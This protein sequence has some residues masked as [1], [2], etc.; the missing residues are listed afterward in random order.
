M[1]SMTSRRMSI[2]AEPAAWISNTPASGISSQVYG[3]QRG[4][5]SS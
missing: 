1:A 4:R 5:P 2:P 3:R